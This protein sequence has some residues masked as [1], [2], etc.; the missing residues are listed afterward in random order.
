MRSKVRPLLAA[1]LTVGSLASVGAGAIVTASPALAVCPP[2]NTC[3]M[4]PP[5]PPPPPV[6]LS[7]SG[8]LPDRNVA[9]TPSPI[10]PPAIQVGAK[11]SFTVT[12]SSRVSGATVALGGEDK[13]TCQ[14]PNG[15]NVTFD[16]VYTPSF[17]ASPKSVTKQPFICP[18]GDVLTAGAYQLYAQAENA[19]GSVI[20][21][22]PTQTFQFTPQISLYNVLVPE[23]SSGVD[24]GL[25]LVP[26]DTVTF[27]ASGQIWAGVILTGTNGPLGW[28]DYDG[29]QSK[30]PLLCAPPYSLIGYLDNDG[31][32]FY[33]GSGGGAAQP[34]YPTL[35]PSG[36][37]GTRISDLY[38]D[39]PPL[40]LLNAPA[41]LVLRT[42]DD[43]PGN[44]SGA[45]S[46][47]IQVNRDNQ[48]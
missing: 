2:G 25:T 7:T 5:P 47:N 32:Y 43:A 8:S 46:V 38:P 31:G 16:Y 39:P 23:L 24:T 22:T 41:E 14:S 6:M 20:G 36:V 12:A 27:T 17:T 9:L 35:S 18:I 10:T 48:F 4:P 44:G 11:E 26:G 34:P 45:F 42:N 28:T 33:I 30:F 29:C 37:I 21:T 13:F 1:V 15:V 3:G 40:N 19:S